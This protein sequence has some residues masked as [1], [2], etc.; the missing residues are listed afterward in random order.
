MIRPSQNPWNNEVVLVRKKDGG[1]RFCV[2]FWKLNARMKRHILLVK[3]FLL[4]S[5]R[6]LPCAVLLCHFPLLRHNMR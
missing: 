6:E 4:E 5:W 1:L 3:W 2:D